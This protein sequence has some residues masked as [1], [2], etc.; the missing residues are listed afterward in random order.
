M[1]NSRALK[2]GLAGLA[3]TASVLT[4]AVAPAQASAAPAKPVAAQSSAAAS[5]AQAK[6]G[7]YVTLRHQTKKFKGKWKGKAFSRRGHPYVQ[8]VVRCWSGGD[9]TKFSV[10]M[11]WR[12]Y[13]IWNGLWWKGKFPCDGKKRYFG[14]NFKHKTLRAEFVLH[15]KKHTL[16][17][18][19]QNYIRT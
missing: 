17:Y 6:R 18:W 14:T 5:D 1:N 15:G 13:G 7:Y 9:G 19:A 4:V 8:I 11:A 3:A 12:Y 10:G 16:E 2:T